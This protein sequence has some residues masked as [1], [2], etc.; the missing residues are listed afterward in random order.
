MS[1]AAEFQV[2]AAEAMRWARLADNERDQHA[3]ITLAHT[4]MQVA[5]QSEQ[6]ALEVRA[7]RA[8]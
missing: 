2:Y 7:C 8:A 6:P 1:T 3:L 5:V 4:W